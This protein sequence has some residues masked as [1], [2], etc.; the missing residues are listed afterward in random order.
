MARP[1]SVRLRATL[2]ATLLVA[3]ALVAASVAL[4]VVLAHSLI[5][6]DDDLAKS[7]LD[8][9]GALATS[10]S[11]PRVLPSIGDDS[12]AQVVRDDGL[13]VASSSNITAADRIAHFTPPPGGHA[14]Q[15]V[16]GAPDDRETEDYRLWA[17]GASTPEGPV[18]LYVGTSLESVH[19]VTGRLTRLLAWGVPV[20]VALLGLLTWLVVGRA[21]RPVDRMRAQVSEISDRAGDTRVPLPGTRDELQRLAL[22]MNGMLDRL[23]GA[24][25]RQREFVANASHDLQSP[26]T[27]IRAELDVATTHPE[28][29][30]WPQLVRTVRAEAERMERLV[31]DLLFLARTDD[32]P[33]PER[34][35]VD[36]DDVV[37]EEV[38][39]LDPGPVRVETR[40]VS[41]APV[42]GS[43]DELARLVRN[44]L[45]NACAHARGA[46][47]ISTCREDGAQVLVVHDDGPGV[48][49]QH[50]ARVFERFF[51]TDDSRSRTAGGTGLGLAIV[52]SVAQSHGG[53]VRVDGEGGGARFEV[54]LPP[55]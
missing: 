25:V 20:V 21:L 7:R 36:L 51:R 15:T 44:L 52:R 49:E 50:R 18:T 42:R 27:V 40:G 24:A 9:L 17:A 34:G 55:G 41:A 33:A 3:V 48:P 8:D 2:L 22:T 53:S 32:R 23:E 46:V 54:R 13:V 31:Q 11:L 30:D 1:L 28:A 5:T 12:V 16:R 43:R 47:T 26:L 38:A 6:S 45:A 35:L 37:L 39:R 19:E 29:T 10:G 14:V 4:V